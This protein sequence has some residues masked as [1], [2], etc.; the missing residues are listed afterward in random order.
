MR[1]PVATATRKSLSWQG[2]ASNRTTMHGARDGSSHMHVSLAFC[3]MP[4]SSPL[5]QGTTIQA[6]LDLG[7]LEK[8]ELRSL[9][10]RT[11]LCYLVCCP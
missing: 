9:I 5:D 10:I 3:S 11:E 1:C 4:P 8:S 6:L 7:E 2:M